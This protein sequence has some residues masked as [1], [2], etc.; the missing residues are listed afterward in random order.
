MRKSLFLGLL[1]VFVTAS[2]HAGGNAKVNQ[3]K[4]TITDKQGNPLVGAKVTVKG[5]QKEAYTDFEGNFT[6]EEVSA[7]ALK[8]EVSHIS[9]E[10]VEKSFDFSKKDNA[11]IAFQLR[12]R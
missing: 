11:Y 3:V 2:L 8:L 7:E 5:M 4:G 1:L 6:L 9:Y 12:S 10:E